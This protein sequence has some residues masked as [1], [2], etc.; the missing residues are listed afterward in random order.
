MLPLGMPYLI[1]TPTIVDCC[2][3]AARLGLAFVELNNSFPACALE[4]LDAKTLRRMGADHGLY[5]TLHAHEECDPFSFCP[6]VR[7]AWM[8]YLECALRLAVEAEMP[9]VNMHLADGVY[10]TLPNKR[11]YL[12]AQYREAY[13]ARAEALRALAERVLMGTQ[14]RLC[15][16]NTSGFQPH[17]LEAL[18]TLLASPCIGLTLDIGHDHAIHGHDLP[19]Y[20]AHTQKLWHMH[21]HDARGTHPHLA[22]GDGE[23]DW[24]ARFDLAQRCGARIVLEVKTLEA[25]GRSVETAQ[26]F[27]RSK[28]SPKGD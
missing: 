10:I 28:A 24:P 26:R 20:L 25:L 16:E 3:A 9:T 13:C 4:T 1:E 17:T 6:E 15:I 5:M 22:L 11:V 2:D 7:Q 12:Y 19:F 21:G 23:L 18:E 14:T 8:H 27:L